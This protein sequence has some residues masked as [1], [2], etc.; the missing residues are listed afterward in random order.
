MK[1]LVILALLALTLLPCVAG[2]KSIG[3]GA[4]GG[5]SVPILQD[6]N[7]R[8]T[9][10]GIRVPVQLVPLIT[11]EPLFAKTS[12]GNK[13]QAVSGLGTISRSGMDVSTFGA[14]V[15]LTFGGKF[16][17]YP[18]LGIGSFKQTRSGSA[19]LTKSGYNFGLGLGLSPAPKISIHVRGELDSAI[20]G[21][22]ARKWANVTAGVSYS[23]F[24][25]P[26]P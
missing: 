16:Q 3:V 9:L 22:T 24:S 21:D 2:A 4:F 25:F 8:G 18:F 26:A 15:L 10:F 17:L 5:A 6:D 19:D 7:G 23:L 14:N 13:D 20:D 11:V 1:R 12:G